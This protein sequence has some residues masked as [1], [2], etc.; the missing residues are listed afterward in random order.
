MNATNHTDGRERL[1]FTAGSVLSGLAYES[2]N[3]DSIGPIWAQQSS[4]SNGTF[5]GL[6]SDS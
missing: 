6:R 3:I 4:G 1:Y 5:S 2:A